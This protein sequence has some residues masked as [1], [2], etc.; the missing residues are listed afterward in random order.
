MTE[1]IQRNERVDTP[2]Q[3]GAVQVAKPC[4]SLHTAHDKIYKVVLSKYWF[5]TVFL[6]WFG[7]V[8]WLPLPCRSAK[9]GL[10]RIDKWRQQESG[11]R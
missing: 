5:T 2:V 8:V 4:N 6:E 1:R 11:D 10:T 3:G 9:Q 7:L